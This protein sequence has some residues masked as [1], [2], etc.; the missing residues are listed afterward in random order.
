MQPLNVKTQAAAILESL[1]QVAKNAADTEGYVKLNKHNHPEGAIM[2]VSVEIL[3]SNPQGEFFA[4]AHY[5]EQ[6]GDLVPDPTMTFFRSNQKDI[7]TELPLFIPVEYQDQRSFQ[8]AVV[9]QEDGFV[10]AYKPSMTKDLI[11]FTTLWMKNI[12]QQQNIKP[13]KYKKQDNS[14]RFIIKN[15]QRAMAVA[16][17]LGFPSLNEALQAGKENEILTKLKLA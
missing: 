17:E 3:H 13:V 4:V 9:F 1:F 6:N 10:K 5:F 11:A 16:K 14:S 7:E 2:P 12:R 8:E 15:Y